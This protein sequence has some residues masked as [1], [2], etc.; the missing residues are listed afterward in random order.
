[1]GPSLPFFK[2]YNLDQ[3]KKKEERK[4][5]KD[6][7][8]QNLVDALLHTTRG[9]SLMSKKKRLINGQGRKPEKREFS[10][11]GRDTQTFSNSSNSLAD[12]YNLLHSCKVSCYWNDATRFVIT[13]HSLQ[14][15]CCQGKKIDR[16]D[17]WFII[18]KD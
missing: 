16:M 10:K 7:S 6:T 18:A 1:M 14:N 12:L 3:R 5:A 11:G 8:I 17:R 2:I 15:I 4:K 9:F 13:S